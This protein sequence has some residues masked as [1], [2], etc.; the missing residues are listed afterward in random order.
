[1]KKISFFGCLLIVL[2]SIASHANAQ[3]ITYT[4]Q[5]R[6][7]SYTR[8][9]SN[10]FGGGVSEIFNLNESTSGVDPFEVIF[11]G[12]DFTVTDPFG[13]GP[14]STIQGAEVAASQSSS[15]N[16]NGITASGSTDASL[17]FDDP[18]AIATI[19][20]SASSSFFSAFDLSEDADFTL[21]LSATGSFSVTVSRT[22][23]FAN[24]GS[25]FSGQSIS[26]SGV[27]EAG[28]Y[29]VT[30]DSFGNVGTFDIALQIAAVPEPS[31]CTFLLSALFLGMGVRRRN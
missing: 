22:D 9:S 29:S 10:P 12:A 27:L 15:L 13:F 23:G 17:L 24:I 16:F 2:I 26:E 25:V 6:G 19:S 20:D 11:A 21:D 5:F 8:T 28:Q 30:V 3:V 4:E 1:M 18:S 14:P 31:S 7:V